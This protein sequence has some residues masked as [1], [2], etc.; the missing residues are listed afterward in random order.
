MAS[1]NSKVLEVSSLRSVGSIRIKQNIIYHSHF[2]YLQNPCPWYRNL[3]T[4]NQQLFCNWVMNQQNKILGY[5]LLEGQ[6]LYKTP[7]NQM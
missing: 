1:A 4:L 6:A 2:P 5:K 7:Y 3:R